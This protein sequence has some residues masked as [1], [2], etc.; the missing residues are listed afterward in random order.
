M[1]VSVTDGY[2]STPSAWTVRIRE[3]LGLPARIASRSAALFALACVWEFLSRTGIVN[4]LFLPPFSVV[5]ADVYHGFATGYLGQHVMASLGRAVPGLLLALLVGVPLGLALE[6]SRSLKT[7]IDPVVEVLRNT[8]AL[9]LLPVFTLMLGI[10]ET[11]KI[12]MVFYAALWPILLGTMNGLR[13]VDPLWIKAGRSMGLSGGKLFIK[14]VIPASLPSI[15]TGIRLAAAAG[16]L[17]LVAAEM[18]GSRAGLGYVI[19]ASQL[20]FDLPGMYAAILVLSV[21]GYVTNAV[22]VRVEA[23]FLQWKTS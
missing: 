4:P 21:V 16:L 14:I 10:G 8:S 7:F 20:D 19:N 9:A 1:S 5:I 11:S 6:A 13:G 23:H 15:F 12:A 17:V 22:L 3:G 18:V 2:V